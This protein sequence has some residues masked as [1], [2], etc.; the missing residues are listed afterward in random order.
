ML[1]FFLRITVISA[2]KLRRMSTSLALSASRA[3][4]KYNLATLFPKSESLFDLRPGRRWVG[5]AIR[6]NARIGVRITQ[7]GKIIDGDRSLSV[8]VNYRRG[9]LLPAWVVALL[10]SRSCVRALQTATAVL[11]L[12]ISY[13]A[14]LAVAHRPHRLIPTNSIAVLPVENTY[15]SSGKDK[16]ESPAQDYEENRNKNA[17]NIKSVADKQARNLSL[18]NRQVTPAS[19]TNDN[20]LLS[21]QPVAPPE[22]ESLIDGKQRAAI[23]E[24]PMSKSVLDPR[25]PETKLEAQVLTEKGRGNVQ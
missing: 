10:Q 14:Y 5:K 15:T 16:P 17:R 6:G 22:P 9:I 7:L 2:S 3:K 8:D 23:L 18:H 20:Q 24:I 13:G 11:V 21:R 4:K 25:K 12:A 1:V 19:N